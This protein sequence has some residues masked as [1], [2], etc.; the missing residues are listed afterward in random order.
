M[1]DFRCTSH[2]ICVKWSEGDNEFC[3]FRCW[4]SHEICVNMTPITISFLRLRVYIIRNLCQMQPIRLRFLWFQMLDITPAKPVLKWPQLQFDSLDF[5]CTSHDICVR[6]HQ[7]GFVFGNF[8]CWL[9]HKISASQVQ[10]DSFFYFRCTSHEI[11]VKWHKGFVFRD[12]RRWTSHETRVRC[13]QGGFDFMI[14]EVGHH[15]KSVSNDTKVWFFVIL[16]VGH[17]TKFVSD[18]TKEVLFYDFRCWT[19]HEI[20][21][22]ITA[23]IISFFRFSAVLHTKSVW[24]YTK[25]VLFLWFQMLDITRNLCKSYPNYNL[26]FYFRCSSHEIC[27]KWSQGDNEFCDFRCWISQGICV[28]MT[29]TELS[30]FRLRVY[31]IRNLCQMQSIWLRFCDFRYWTSHEICVKMTPITINFHS[32]DFG[33]TSHDICVRCHQGGFVFG[34]YRCWISHKTS[35]PLVQ[36]FFLFQVYFTRNLCQMTRRR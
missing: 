22:K 3:D 14:S 27:V 7:G 6:C 30:I 9:F 12:F 10:F 24:D 20:C 28:K 25:E 33:C 18:A 21:V 35:V 17:H 34:N 4:I 26:I 11:C 32:L 13:N 1:F 36:L 15:T 2:E 19:S 31:F 16:D 29:P 23:I 5:G 8:R